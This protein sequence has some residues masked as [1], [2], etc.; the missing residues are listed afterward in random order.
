MSITGQLQRRIAK[1]NLLESRFYQAWSEGE[2]PLAGL[3]KYAEEYGDFIRLLPLGWESLKDSETAE[4]ERE[5]VESWES[6]A[7]ALDTSIREAQLPRVRELSWK[8]ES[9]FS[10]P[11][12]ALG[13][14]YAFEAQQPLT[15]QSKLEGLRE[16]YS[17][18]EAA[19]QY[20]ILHSDNQHESEKLL[21]QIEALPADEQEIAFSACEQMSEALWDALDGIYEDS[22]S[23]N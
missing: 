23:L 9:L 13:A 16:H 5:H 20:F 7:G 2:L 18:T 6:F 1:W 4:E 12:S 15:A 8:A 3:Q 19:E 22:V 11:T 10:S 21:S 17:L 14:L